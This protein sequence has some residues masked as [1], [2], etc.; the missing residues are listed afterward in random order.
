MFIIL[1][2]FLQIIYIDRSIVITDIIK[3]PKFP[4]LLNILPYI[5]SFW[6]RYYVKGDF[7][8]IRFVFSQNHS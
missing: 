1:G 8:L 3:P 2:S 6:L 4:Y 7:Y 5:L